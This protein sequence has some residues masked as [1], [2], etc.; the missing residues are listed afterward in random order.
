MIVVKGKRHLVLEL[1]NTE[2]GIEIDGR[3]KF[4]IYINEKEFHRTILWSE[5]LYNGASATTR[6]INFFDAKDLD[7]IWSVSPFR[8]TI[9]YRQF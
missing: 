4:E 5:R 6:A 7:A 3:L 1:Y 8:Y 2:K 9:L